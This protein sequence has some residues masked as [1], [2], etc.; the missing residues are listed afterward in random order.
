MNALAAS[1]VS[2]P[3]EEDVDWKL[4]ATISPCYVTVFHS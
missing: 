1:F 4:S 2:S 3:A